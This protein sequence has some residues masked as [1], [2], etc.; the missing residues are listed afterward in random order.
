VDGFYLAG[1]SALALHLGHRCSRDLDLFSKAG[2]AD[3]DALKAAVR[4][5][6]DDARTLRQT[7]ASLHLLCDGVPIDFVRY[8]YGL[9][10]NASTRAAPVAVAGVTDLCV[11]KLAAIARRGL[12][13]DFWDVYEV[14][15]SGRLSLQEASEA[16]V[17]RFGVAEADLYHV[18]RSLTFFVDAE[19]DPVMPAGL[20]QEHWRNIK[21]F[22]E[23]QVPALVRGR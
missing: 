22:F 10:E 1:G 6:F 16:Y 17:R 19:R 5:V 20:T 18:Y 21:A 9:L 13:R 12:R 11:M 7:D 8:P 14:V 2:D 23:R 15:A 3:L 4:A